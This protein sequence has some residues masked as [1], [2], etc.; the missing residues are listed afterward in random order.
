M[1]MKMTLKMKNRSYTY[2]INRP[3]SRHGHQYTKYKMCLS[4]MVVIFIK[5]HPTNTWSSI[6]EKV[7]QH[8][9]WAEKKALLIKK[10]MVYIKL[11][12]RSLWECY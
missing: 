2:D 12:F 4:I 1:A 7:K 5:Q 9:G 11:F 3:W 6:H 8:W 10:K